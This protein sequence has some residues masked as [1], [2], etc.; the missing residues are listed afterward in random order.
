MAWKFA[1]HPFGYCV[2]VV[3]RFRGV[4]HEIV[5]PC[6]W[7]LCL[8]QGL[9]PVLAT[10]SAVAYLTICAGRSVGHRVVRRTGRGS[11]AFQLLAPVRSGLF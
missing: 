1:E 2:I 6:V 11:A 8:I 7:V 9:A 4:S 5:R 10:L 3:S